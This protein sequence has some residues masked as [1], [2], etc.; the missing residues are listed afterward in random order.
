[1]SVSRLALVW[2]VL[3]LLLAASIG[4]SFLPIG[5]IREDISLAI[6]AVKALLILWFFMDLRRSEGLDR[7]ALLGTIT[8]LA[9]MAILTSADYLTRGWL[10]S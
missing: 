7:L 2:L 4:A 10:G 5:P 3:S 6:A 1:M 8:F 9:A